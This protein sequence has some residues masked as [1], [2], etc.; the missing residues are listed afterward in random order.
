MNPNLR[1]L[2]PT[3]GAPFFSSRGKKIVLVIGGIIA[4]VIILRALKGFTKK[5]DSREEVREAYNELEQANT[6]PSTRQKITPFQ[7]QQYANTLFTAM[8]GYGT[9]EVAIYAV[10]YR[11][12]NDA[13]F[14]AVSKSFGVREVSSGNLNPEPNMKG[15]M[16]ECLHNELDWFERNKLNDILKKKKIKFR[17]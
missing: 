1:N 8:N 12:S 17:V 4:G 16:T 10:F 5:Q 11:L 15:T 13:D 6:N 2:I 3:G 14:L 9:D 7:A